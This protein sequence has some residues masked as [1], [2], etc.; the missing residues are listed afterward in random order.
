L[1]YYSTKRMGNQL[2]VRG[3]LQELHL[4]DLGDGLA[5]DKILGPGRLLKS[6]QCW[7]EEGFKKIKKIKKLTRHASSCKSIFKKTRRF[8]IRFGSLPQ[9]FKFLQ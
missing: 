5:Q 4:Q 8:T 1:D 9:S 3:S 2:L 7:T 6:V